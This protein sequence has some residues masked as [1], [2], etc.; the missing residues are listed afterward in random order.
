[1]QLLHMK[2]D[3]F[4]PVERTGPLFLLMQH[5]RIHGAKMK[6]KSRFRGLRMRA[7]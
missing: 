7:L 5:F 3:K 1:M 2:G 6:I 4:S